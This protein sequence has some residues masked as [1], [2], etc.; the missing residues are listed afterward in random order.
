MRECEV[1]YTVTGRR[2]KWTPVNE[3]T[4]SIL[5]LNACL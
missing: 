4:T 3:K 2:A 5:T 1:V